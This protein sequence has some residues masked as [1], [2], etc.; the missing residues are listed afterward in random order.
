MQSCR[1][2]MDDG[3]I[4]QGYY[5]AELVHLDNFP[6]S[7]LTYGNNGRTKNKRKLCPRRV[8][9]IPTYV[10]SQPRDVLGISV[11]F[12]VIKRDRCAV[13]KAVS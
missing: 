8:G 1:A 13:C 12:C 10:R 2:G 9:S 3:I 11:K 5:P 6:V 4:R 7:Y